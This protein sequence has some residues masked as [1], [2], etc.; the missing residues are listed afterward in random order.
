MSWI[1]EGLVTNPA[2]GAVLADSGPLPAGEYGLPAVLVSS[3]VAV[4]LVLQHRNAANNGNV[5]S[6]AIPVAAMTPF[7]LPPPGNETFSG[8]ERLRLVVLAAVVGRMQASFFV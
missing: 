4:I 2:A 3:E 5:R 8:G 1:T 7:Y 6:H